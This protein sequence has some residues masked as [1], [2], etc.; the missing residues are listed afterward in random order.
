MWCC[1]CCT[2]VAVFIRSSCDWKFAGSPEAGAKLRFRLTPDPDTRRRWERREVLLERYKQRIAAENAARLAAAQKLLEDLN[3]DEEGRLNDGSAAASKEN[4]R[5]NSSAAAASE[6][7]KAQ[8][9]RRR[10]S[11]AGAAYSVADTATAAA[12]AAN[13]A[14]LRPD[15]FDIVV[16]VGRSW[17]SQAVHLIPGRYFAFADVSFNMPYEQAFNM[18]LPADLS[19][20][21]W[22]D[23]K[24]PENIV[25][26]R[27]DKLK[28]FTRAKR[29]DMQQVQSKSLVSMTDESIQQDE[30]AMRLQSG[31]NSSKDLSQLPRVWLQA[32][33][34]DP[35]AVHAMR[36]ESVPHSVSPSLAPL[37]DKVPPEVWPFSAEE[38]GE[39]STRCL[40]NMLAKAK[41]DAQLVGLEFMNLAAQYKELRK[42]MLHR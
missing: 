37:L 28:D 41:R 27:N 9:L 39:A 22:L 30:D 15:R 40:V 20:A 23:G 3:A 17:A 12:A 7:I 16:T 42:S 14:A 18:T 5:K 34:L 10:S 21:P 32:S 36:L 6:S 11:S 29:S 33:S 24:S 1:L 2:G 8:P 19:D 31:G 13:S 26:R 35:C 25:N 38:Q 4:H